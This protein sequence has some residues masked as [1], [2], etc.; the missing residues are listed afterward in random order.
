M[1]RISDWKELLNNLNSVSSLLVIRLKLKKE[2]IPP[3]ILPYW[4]ITTNLA[5]AIQNGL[6]TNTEKFKR[7]WL[8]FFI[9]YLSKRMSSEKFQPPLLQSKEGVQLLQ[10]LG[11]VNELTHQRY[12]NP[13]IPRQRIASRDR[14]F[15]TLFN[16][17]VEI[18]IRWAPASHQLLVAL[19]HFGL[20]GNGGAIAMLSEVFN[21]SEGSIE[22]FTNQTLQ[23]ILDLEDRYV[24]WPTPQERVAMIDSLPEDNIFR[25][26]VGFVDGMIIP[27][28]SA[29]TKNKEDCWMRKMLYAVNSLLVC[30]WNKRI[31]YSFHGW[32]GSAHDQQVYKNSRFLLADSAYTATDTVV[33]AFKQSGGLPLP[34]SKQDFNYQ[35]SSWRVAIEQCIGILKNRWQSLKSSRLLIRGS[36]SAA[37]LNVWLRVCVILHNFL[38]GQSTS[39]WVPFESNLPEE[40]L[41]LDLDE[42]KLENCTL[43]DRLFRR[44]RESNDH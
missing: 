27:L 39:N 25:N 5:C 13:R 31:I 1:P 15:N 40:V 19:A 32:C 41:S 43:R 23:A 20:S 18:F 26:C 38:R 14:T 33:P 7:S 37:R 12:L 35:L 2:T 28:E 29:P 16:S 11:L 44:F 34:K 30:D 36:T 3:S 4:T 6:Q 17:K 42:D 9:I 22:N 21:V 8:F 24:K 10:F